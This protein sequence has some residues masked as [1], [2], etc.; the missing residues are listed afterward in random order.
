[1]VEGVW[2]EVEV[3]AL[4]LRTIGFYGFS[5]FFWSLIEFSE[6]KRVRKNEKS[7]S[8][9][10]CPSSRCCDIEV[11]EEKRKAQHL[12]TQKKINYFGPKRKGRSRNCYGHVPGAQVVGQ[13]Y[14]L[15]SH[16]PILI[17]GRL[18]RPTESPYC[19]RERE[20][21]KTGTESDRTPSETQ[22]SLG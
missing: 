16:R 1:V 11:E 5:S 7:T 19:S 13:G 8:F 15:I 6:R 10:L 3:K 4:G 21:A 17:Q 12:A 18:T 2:G 9:V 14:S 20:Q 22:I